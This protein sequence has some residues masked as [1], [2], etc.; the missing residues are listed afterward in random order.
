MSK[1]YDDI[2]DRIIILND[3]EETSQIMNQLFY[4]AQKDKTSPIHI[5]INT[6]GG[7][8]YDMLALYDAIKYVQSCGI[9]VMTIGL[10][11]IMSSGVILL[12]SGTERKIG[13]NATLMWHWGHDS[14]E[15][16]IFQMENDLS[17]MKRLDHLCNEILTSDTKLS[18][19]KIEELLSTKTDVY[20]TSEQ[21]VEYGIVDSFLENGPKKKTTRKRNKKTK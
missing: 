15:G 8:I 9:K 6:Y 12:S 14:I 18:K 1:K 4:L 20:I 13:K 21:A 11:K 5:I 2:D 10:G 16:N 7:E 19:D 17:E 3:L